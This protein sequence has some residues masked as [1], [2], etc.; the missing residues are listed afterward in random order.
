M[1]LSLSEQHG[2]NK[3]IIVPGTGFWQIYFGCHDNGRALAYGLAG[4][5]INPQIR[6]LVV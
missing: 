4:S 1:Q 3:Q 5:L 6:S 2:E